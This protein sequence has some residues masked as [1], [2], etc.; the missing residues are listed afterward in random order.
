MVKPTLRQEYLS[1]FTD[2]NATVIPY[3]PPA[4]AS[5]FSYYHDVLLKLVSFRLH[6]YVPY[7][8]RILVLDSDQLILQSLD[9]MF[10]LPKVDVAAP[11]M[12]WGDETSTLTSA[13]MLITPSN[14]LWEKVRKAIDT[15]GADQFDMEILNSLFKSNALVL[16]GD[17][18]TLNS[19]W[20]VNKMPN[21]WQGE[22]PSRDPEWV[23]DVPLPGL[24]TMPKQQGRKQTPLSLS[25]NRA[26]W[27]A[28]PLERFSDESIEENPVDSITEESQDLQGLSLDNTESSEKDR[29]LKQRSETS[30]SGE[31][32]SDQAG[33][34]PLPSAEKARTFEDDLDKDWP[35]Y[36]NFVPS[37]E[38]AKQLEAQRQEEKYKSEVADAELEERGTRLHDLLVKLYEEEVKVLHYTAYGKP[39]QSPVKR[40][41]QE[42][43]HAH[44]LLAEQM[45]VWRERAKEIC[46]GFESITV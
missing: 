7:L 5:G 37:G 23:P 6:Q 24:R 43:K 12:Y 26:S 46:P 8:K 25:S 2:Y 45:A 40:V 32:G 22:E 27:E 10:S 42:R 41:R 30:T 18:C 11:R 35:S 39:W 38:Y 20:E 34:A 36:E 44:P 28:D 3:T 15:I 16:P 19:E 33:A 31:I 9:H 13:M 1:L 29:A 17:Y 14:R 21:W 4:L